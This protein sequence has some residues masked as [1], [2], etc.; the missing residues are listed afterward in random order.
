MDEPPLDGDVV[1][2]AA[3]KAG[4]TPLAVWLLV[5]R[6]HEHLTPRF[7]EYRRRYECIETSEGGVPFLVSAG[8]WETVGNQLEFTDREVGAVRRA[9]EE[10][11]RRLGRQTDRADE[12]ETALEI[13]EVVILAAST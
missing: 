3:A 11:F 2:L 4:V 9:H 8:H 13:R 10:Q 5:E 7:D 1:T 6:A 12:F